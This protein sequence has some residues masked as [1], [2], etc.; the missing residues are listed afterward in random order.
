MAEVIL[1][2]YLF[3]MPL[4]NTEER[5]TD[6]RVF[7]FDWWFEKNG[8]KCLPS[9]AKEND[10]GFWFFIVPKTLQKKGKKFD[11]LKL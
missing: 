8:S 1:I 7:G 11:S 2:S 10:P 4:T 6:I 9:I 5:H 3:K